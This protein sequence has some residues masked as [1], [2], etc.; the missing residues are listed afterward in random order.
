MSLQLI[1]S[2]RGREEGVMAGRGFPL[3][4]LSGRGFVR[5]WSA[6]DLVGNV[7]A[8]A[9]LTWASLRAFATFVRARP[10]V[11]VGAGG[12]ASLPPGVATV[13]LRIPLVLLNA[14]VEPGLADRVLGRMADT[15]RSPTRAPGYR[16]PW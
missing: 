9:G 14:D 16:T 3:L 6:A 5:S 12:Y 1:G 4:R 15:S 11:V 7:A 13:A 8:A 10:R 2:K